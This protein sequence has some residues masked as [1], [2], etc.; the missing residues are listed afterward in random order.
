M[1]KKRF[2]VCAATKYV[3]GHI[4][5]GSRHYSPLMR[6]N[7]E[8]KYGTDY[9]NWPEEEAQGFIDQY[10]IFMTRDEA[11]KVAFEM[12]QIKEDFGG[13]FSEQLY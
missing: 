9:K 4:E 6:K 12:G 3:D 2:V 13:L 7:M 1:N 5:L 10:D 11:S 8:D